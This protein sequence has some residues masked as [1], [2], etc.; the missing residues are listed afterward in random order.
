MFGHLVFY[1]HRRNVFSLYFCFVY[2]SYSFNKLLVY[3]IGLDPAFC[4]IEITIQ[5]CAQPRFYP[6]NGGCSRDS[7][8]IW[9]EPAV[10]ETYKYSQIEHQKSSLSR[11]EFGVHSHESGF[12]ICIFNLKW[13]EK[14][15]YDIW[16]WISYVKIN[17]NV[18]V[19]KRKL[20]SVRV[21]FSFIPSNCFH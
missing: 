12:H 7:S 13:L 18:E 9:L 3:S 4:H 2:L 6:M 17:Q 14:I 15:S 1:Y 21:I 11:L 16:I 10:G 5:S 20:L 19:L 8:V